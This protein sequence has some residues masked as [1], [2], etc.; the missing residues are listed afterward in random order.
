MPRKL[1]IENRLYNVNERLA[2]LN[3]TER[4]EEWIDQGLLADMEHCFLPFR[5]GSNAD[6]NDEEGIFEM[7]IKALASCHGIAGFFD[8]WTYYSGCAFE[9]GCGYAWGYP[10][11]LITT[12]IYKS[13][14]G[15]SKDFYYASK[16]TQHI[17]RIVGISSLNPEIKDYRERHKDLLERALTALRINLIDDFGKSGPP[18]PHLKALPIVYDYYIDPNFKYSESGEKL[19]ARITS[20]ISAAGRTCITGDNQGDIAAD[21]DNLRQSGQGIFFSDVGEPNVDSGILQGIAYGIGR[22]PIV[23]ASNKQRILMSGQW[24]IQLNTMLTYSASAVVTSMAELE[25]LIS[26]GSR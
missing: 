23:Y 22:K 13:S 25:A 18:S 21:I 17:A 2:S 24:V 16:L 15:D 11:H 4:I 8:G 9:I 3:L 7:D 1:Y 19:L 20:A 14:V 5:N 26:K 6:V 12:D 10:I